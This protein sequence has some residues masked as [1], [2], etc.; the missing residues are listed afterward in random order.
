VTPL[1]V[2]IIIMLAVAPF[3]M[4]T[5]AWT[6]HRRRIA[7]LRRDAESAALRHAYESAARKRE[8]GDVKP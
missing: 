4:D 7:A 2:L 5:S 8:E 1:L 3:V 6:N